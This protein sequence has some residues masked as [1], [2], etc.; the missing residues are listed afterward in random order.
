MCT[1]WPL[2]SAFA[3]PR[4]SCP[5]PPSADAP[6]R[7]P[8][9]STDSGTVSQFD[10]T[11]KL[12]PIF[13][14]QA[15]V[16]GGPQRT[17]YI[18]VRES[19]KPWTAESTLA[20]IEQQL[21]ESNLPRDKWV[22]AVMDGASVN[23][24]ACKQAGVAFRV[25]ANHA[26]HN[27]A[28]RWL[29][30]SSLI[31]SSVDKFKR[32][33]EL[34]STSFNAFAGHWSER[35]RALPTGE[36]PVKPISGTYGKTWNLL[37]KHAP[38]VER[39][40][41]P[42]AELLR[43]PLAGTA[44]SP[45]KLWKTELLQLLTDERLMTFVRV[46]SALWTKLLQPVA[47]RFQA[48]EPVEDVMAEVEQLRVAMAD[49]DVGADDDALEILADFQATMEVQLGHYFSGYEQ[50]LTVEQQQ[51]ATHSTAHVERAFAFLKQRKY[52]NA[53]TGRHLSTV[54]EALGFRYNS[55]FVS[56]DQ[57]RQLPEEKQQEA[58]QQALQLKRRPVDATD[59]D[60]MADA[61]SAEVVDAAQQQGHEPGAGDEPT[62]EDEPRP[63]KA[64]RQ[65][66]CRSVTGCNKLCPSLDARLVHEKAHHPDEKLSKPRG[67][68][69]RDPN[70]VA[71]FQC[72]KMDT[73][74]ERCTRV[75]YTR[76]GRRQH[77]LNA[78]LHTEPGSDDDT[79]TEAASTSVLTVPAAAAASSTRKRKARSAVVKS[80]SSESEFSGVDTAS[81]E[82][83]PAPPVR[84][85]KRPRRATAQPVKYQND[86]QDGD[87]EDEDDEED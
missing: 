48:D 82:D 77:E 45:F 40:L 15:G 67:T 16:D 59:S 75:F 3:P 71:A 65:A 41:E 32:L 17:T 63:K 52:G 28:D 25:D 9:P 54:H 72:T 49:V 26:L 4:R 70:A 34:I 29:S 85:S 23:T 31:K 27:S 44:Q 64:A 87:G 13:V 37:F 60:A 33:A 24:A 56:V 66:R 50:P 68:Q 5:L 73:A 36:G 47:A 80:D 79:L 14:T 42:F 51:C 19:R 22:L 39:C 81:D 10:A 78:R 1:V 55:Q 53:T 61:G 83:G 18:G 30:Q 62:A 74:G 21:V 84:T 2:A 8:S 86:G 57:L 11:R 58:Y 12:L 43:S 38:A 35:V 46:T 7:P 6:C 69:P 20:A 76:V